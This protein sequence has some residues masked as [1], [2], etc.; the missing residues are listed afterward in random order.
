MVHV[1]ALPGT[2]R[3]DKPLSTIVQQAVQEA[4]LLASAGFDAVIVENMHD[5]PY[6]LR[7]V[8]PEII[9]AMTV[10][11]TAVRAA[12]D[13]PLGVQVLAG[14]N[15]AALAVAHS[16]GAQFIRAEGFVFAAVA[17]EGLLETADAGP[18]LRYRRAI[19]AQDVAILVDVKKK[20]SAHA[21]TGDLD[22]AE[23]VR[24]AHFFGADGIIVTGSATGRPVDPSDLEAA[25]QATYLPVLVGSGVTPQG[26]GDLLVHADGLIAGSC[27]KS[28][29]LW[30]NGPDPER[31]AALVQAVQAAR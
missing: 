18:L 10:V 17:D 29:G 15:Q 19:G 11:A 3:H 27:F 21:L 7:Q 1:G 24:A 5:V 30:S 9:A 2:P 4:Q 20:H 28:D 26:A 16:A 8:G 25:R 22:L 23:H 12:V 14:A 13:L 31:C 6:L